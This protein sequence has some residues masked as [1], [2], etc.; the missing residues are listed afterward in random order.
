MGCMEMA[1]FPEKY[2][3]NLMREFY[4]NL[5]DDFAKTESPAFGQVYVRG[6][7][8]DFSP[9]HIAYFLSC[10]HYTK[11]TGTSLKEEVDFD[12]VARVLIGDEGAKKL[13]RMNSNKMPLPYKALF[14]LCYGNNLP[15]TNVTIVL[16]ERAHLSFAFATKKNI[17]LYIVLFK[18]IVRQLDQ[19]K[20]NKIVLSSPCLITE[21]I[22]GCKDLSL[23][24]DIWVNELDPW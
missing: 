6:H 1:I 2:N 17:N 14:K 13:N 23:P 19:R 4:A 10:P 3:D 21:Q 5:T 12:E 9:T 16:K 15:T 20:D 22:L 24:I 8:I 18:N 11:I 7:T